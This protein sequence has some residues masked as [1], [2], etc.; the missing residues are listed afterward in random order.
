[1]RDTGFE[2][3]LHY[4]TLSRAVLARGLGPRDEQSELIAECRDALRREV[5]AFIAR[6]GPIRS[7]APH[8]DS[9][10]RFA[11]NAA[12]LQGEDARM[13][14][15]AFDSNEAMRGRGL[16]AWLTDRKASE[17][18]W[19]GRRDPAQ[20]LSEGLSPILCLTHPNNWSAGLSLWADR[21]VGRG[22]LGPLPGEWRRSRGPIVTA[23]DAPPS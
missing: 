6:Y 10:A 22:F 15:V 8:G 2:V 14:G 23:D 11:S 18:G 19:A 9:R 16:A 21:I 20:L 12:L 4:E 13:Y 5:A 7:V 1:L 17:G 3:G